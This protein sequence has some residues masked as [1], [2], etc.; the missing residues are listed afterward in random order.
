TYF[1]DLL[2]D[3]IDNLPIFF[4]QER[5]PTLLVYNWDGKKIGLSK[6]SFIKIDEG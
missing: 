6:S 2:S 1:I 5:F 3:Q 4:Y